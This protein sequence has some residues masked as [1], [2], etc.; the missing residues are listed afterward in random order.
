MLVLFFSNKKSG[1]FFLQDRPGKNGKIFKIIKF[2]TM[3]DVK[4]ENGI[5]LPNN[6][7]MTPIGTWFRK[8]SLDELPQLINII[9]G[10][11]SLIGPRPL[12]VHYLPL[13]SKE[14][15]R[16]HDVRPGITG[17]AQVNGRNSISWIKKF[18]LDVYYVD[19]I[20]L[21]LDTKIFFQTIKK[22]LLREGVNSS[23]DVTMPPFNG[24]N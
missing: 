7:R 1:I 6:D 22:I 9:K 13:Y 17:W 12:M 19:N 18:E 3:T 5:L 24:F 15:R 16:R 20:S 2:K 14:Q 11:M 21:L 10:D 4:D 23:K 8:L